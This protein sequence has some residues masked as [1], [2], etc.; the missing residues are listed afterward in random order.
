MERGEVDVAQEHFASHLLRERMLSWT[1]AVPPVGSLAPTAL[2]AC[3]GGEQHDL[4][5]LALAVLLRRRAWSVRFL[6]ASTPAEVLESVVTETRPD[7]V[8]VSATSTERFLA[9]GEALRRLA[10]TRTAV[11]LAGAGAT[12][13]VSAALGIE[14]T[15]LDPR[16]LASRL[17]PTQV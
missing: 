16:A 11:L 8:I 9:E 13:E 10:K 2:L 17:S 7:V 12:A 6:G 15:S 3:P 14:S 1:A 5:L 4:G